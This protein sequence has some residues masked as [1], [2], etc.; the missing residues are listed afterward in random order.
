[1]ADLTTEAIAHR[2][3]TASRQGLGQGHPHL[4]TGGA[5]HEWRTPRG[6]G[7]R[8]SGADSKRLD[9]RDV[10]DFTST[11]LTPALGISSQGDWLL[12]TDTRASIRSPKARLERFQ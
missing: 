11:K 9:E 3:G 5:A 10:V 1:M 2:V 8:I 6:T 4:L 7:E 12:L